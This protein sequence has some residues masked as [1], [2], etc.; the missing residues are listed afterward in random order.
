MAK[1]SRAKSY[2]AAALGAGKKLYST[3]K[4]AKKVHKVFKK[5]A[6]HKSKKQKTSH[7]PAQ[8]AIASPITGWSKTSTVKTLHKPHKIYSRL[9][10]SVTD[11]IGVQGASSS[12]AGC[13]LASIA[14]INKTQ[15]QPAIIELFATNSAATA[16]QPNP[17]DAG[18]T[19]LNY[20]IYIRY[21]ENE[22]W[23]TNQSPG[24]AD[25]VL[26]DFILKDDFAI[27]IAPDTFAQS[28][29]NSDK[30]PNAG[31]VATWPFFE[32]LHYKHFTDRYRLVRKRR[33]EL[34]GGRSHRHVFR[35]NFNSMFNTD[36][37]VTYA[38]VKGV[39]IVT[40]AIWKGMPLDTTA[41]TGI[42]T[43]ALE[44]IKLVWA[45]RYLMNMSL[46]STVPENELQGSN[47]FNNAATHLYTQPPFG[48]PVEDVLTQ[49]TGPPTAGTLTVEGGQA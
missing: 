11:S 41:G 25:V 7:A 20:K 8:E 24:V 34:G 23:I 28:A 16:N 5:A 31:D 36:K 37:F 4:A 13:G 29:V 49:Y 1:R 3:F 19:S 15:W 18:G 42:G 46:I 40:L 21:F 38:D 10:H 48:G 44:P 2:S 27:S 9:A 39:S 30:G 12:L 47:T 33:L 43:I 35:V 32:P 26:Y 45:A 14:G 6:G 22:T 17:F